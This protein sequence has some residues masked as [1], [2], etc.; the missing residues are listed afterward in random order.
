MAGLHGSQQAL[1]WGKK[2]E[3]KYE[4]MTSE[5]PKK[6]PPFPHRSSKTMSPCSE[7][8]NTAAATMATTGYGHSACHVMATHWL[9]ASEM[10]S[11][12]KAPQSMKKTITSFH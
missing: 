6:T 3:K 1:G 12:G 8:R 11:K 9:R 10:S 4:G 5:A 2:K 7:F